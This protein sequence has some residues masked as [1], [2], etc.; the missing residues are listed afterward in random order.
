MA[1]AWK[2]EK[3]EKLAIVALRYVPLLEEVKEW[4][5]NGIVSV[6]TAVDRD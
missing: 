3:G 2:R 5:C 1:S 4:L 6:T